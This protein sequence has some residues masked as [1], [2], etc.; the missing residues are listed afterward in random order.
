M[1]WWTARK[2]KSSNPDTRLEAALSLGETRDRRAVPSL[3]GALQDADA[4]V[5]QAAAREL[6]GIG[7]PAAIEPLL[8]LLETS[9][10]QAVAEAAGAFGPAAAKPLVRLLSSLDRDVRRWSTR[11][12]GLCGDPIAV[13]PLSRRLQDKRADIRQEAA[14]ALGR[15]GTADAIE[16]LLGAV[17]GRDP[18]TRRAAASALGTAG[19]ERAIDA[20]VHLCTDVDETVQLAAVSALGAVGGLKAALGLQPALESGKRTVREAAQET[21]KTMPLQPQTGEE[22]AWLAVIAGNFEAALREGTAARAPLVQALRSQ[23]EKTR[24]RAA[25]ALAK[26]AEPATAPELVRALQDNDPT[27]RDAAGEALVAIGAPAAEALLEGLRSPDPALQ[28]RA[29]G[30]IGRITAPN[31]AGALAQTIVRNQTASP[32]Y[33]DSLEAAQAAAAALEALLRAAAGT[34]SSVDLEAIGSLP[35]VMTRDNAIQAEIALDCGELRAL[36]REEISRR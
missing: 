20:L 24:L 32:D 28:K 19:T 4:P 15:I 2:L 16:L 13:E 22:R 30:A 23:A 34:V 14:L 12:L 25:Q 18:E 21:L 8:K 9:P 7:H 26:L 1:I 35:D 5:R 10:D 3:I 11:A 33:P 31:A 27:V 29:A 36:A 6:A 17:D